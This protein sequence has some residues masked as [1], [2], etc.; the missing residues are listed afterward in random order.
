MSYRLTEGILVRIRLVHELFS[1]AL[2]GPLEKVLEMFERDADPVKEIA[3]WECMAVAFLAAVS[4]Q[5][6]TLEKRQEILEVLIRC[7]TRS[8]RTVPNYRH[9]DAKDVLRIA[10]LYGNATPCSPGEFRPPESS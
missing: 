6:Y 10:R 8:L 5:D 3:D 9:L 4:G 2:L 1:E 7:S